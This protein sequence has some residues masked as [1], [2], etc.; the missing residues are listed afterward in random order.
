[1]IVATNSGLTGLAYTLM[2]NLM[3]NL[4]GSFAYKISAILLIAGGTCMLVG[5]LTMGY[6]LT[7]SLFKKNE[8]N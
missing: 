8:K 3:I 6:Y 4:F 2:N 7:K 1:M 5:I